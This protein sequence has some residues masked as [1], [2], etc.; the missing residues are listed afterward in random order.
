VS[1]EDWYRW[2]NAHWSV[3]EQV[4]LG[5]LSRRLRASGR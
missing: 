4:A 5:N 3:G 2:V 1:A